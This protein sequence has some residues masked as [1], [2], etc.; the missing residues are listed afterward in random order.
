MPCAT[1]PLC[2]GENGGYELGLQQRFS[3]T[4]REP[5]AANKVAIPQHVFDGLTRRRRSAVW[6][7]LSVRVVTV[8]APQWT[9]AQKQHVA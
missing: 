8:N 1:R 4:D 7:A 2:P 6:F 9:P 3:A 5:A